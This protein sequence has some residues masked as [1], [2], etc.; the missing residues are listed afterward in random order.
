MPLPSTDTPADG[1]PLRDPSERR[2][3]VRHDC[4][5][6]ILWQFLGLAPKEMPAA[7]I[8]DLSANGLGLVLHQAFPVGK[9]LLLRLPTATLGW[10]SYL[11]RVQNCRPE[12]DGTFRIGCVFIK[13][14]SA[15]DLEAHLQI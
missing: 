3:F 8:F 11:V 7:Q 13:P 5:F 2:A 1:V 15:G 6:G 10:K 9:S 12:R 4:R 14:L